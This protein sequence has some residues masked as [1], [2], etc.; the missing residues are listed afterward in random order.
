MADNKFVWILLVVLIFSIDK[1]NSAKKSN[2]KTQTSATSRIKSKV[3]PRSYHG[4]INTDHYY[5]N[6]PQSQN[7]KPEQQIATYMAAAAGGAYAKKKFDY[8]ENYN[9][10]KQYRVQH[11]KNNAKKDYSIINFVYRA[12]LLVP[13]IVGYYANETNEKMQADQ[14]TNNLV[15]DAKLNYISDMDRIN[16]EKSAKLEG[17]LLKHLRPVN[18]EIENITPI[19]T[20][21]VTKRKISFN[22]RIAQTTFKFISNITGNTD[23]LSNRT[24]KYPIISSDKQEKLFNPVEYIRS[25]LEKNPALKSHFIGD[26]TERLRIQLQLIVDTP[27][28]EPRPGPQITPLIIKDLNQPKKSSAKQLKTNYNQLIFIS[29]TTIFMYRTFL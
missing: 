10:R 8:T 7:L 14:Y 11:K 13:F 19:K 23:F 9:T 17:Y 12:P 26:T 25:L 16:M 4:G 29:V 22:A 20:K 15:N 27:L 5:N 6:Y 2:S 21:I 24:I 28:E 18:S 1:I 3:T